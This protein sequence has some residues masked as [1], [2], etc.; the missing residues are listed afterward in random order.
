MAIKKDG[1]QWRIDIYPNGRNGKRIRKKFS[2]K[3]E[4]QRFEKYVLAKSSSEKEWSP[5]FKDQRTLNDLIN[6][7]Y[8]LHG[9]TLKDGERRKRKLI[10]ISERLQNPKAVEITTKDFSHYRSI[11]L[12][13]DKVSANT[14][15]HEL[16]YLKAVFNEL[17]RAGEWTGENPFKKLKPIK[18]DEKE[19]AWLTKEQIA[20]LLNQLEISRNESALVVTRICLATGARWGEAESLTDQQFRNGKITYSGTKSGKVRSVPFEDSVI[21]SYIKGKNGRLFKACAGAFRKAV[22]RA[23][24]ELPSGQL[25]HVCRHTFA[26][27]YLMNGGDVLTLQKILGHSSL[28]M[29]M[30]Y[31]HFAP[32]H[33]SDVIVRNPIA[34][35]S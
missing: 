18:F 17:D 13:S 26:S 15:N 16:A 32:D 20:G 6:K 3:L 21:D 23:G 19:L 31:A 34:L 28:T 25:T 1:T 12:D 35:L 11:R 8:E 7:W 10:Q 9:Q 22:Q 27:H 14:V 29:T 4:A 24:I 5:S 2:T 33:L 30:R